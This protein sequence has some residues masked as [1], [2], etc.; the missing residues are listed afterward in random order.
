MQPFVRTPAFDEGLF[1]LGTI[2]EALETISEVLEGISEALETISKAL[3]EF[4][5]ALDCAKTLSIVNILTA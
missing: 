5:E 4:S 1:V 3:E 2:S